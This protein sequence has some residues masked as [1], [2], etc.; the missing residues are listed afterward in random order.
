MLN[1]LL[2]ALFP[3]IFFLLG[4]EEALIPK[5]STL[6]A[7]DVAQINIGDG[8]SFIACGC[9]EVGENNGTVLFFEDP[10]ICHLD[11]AVSKLFFIYL[12]T[13]KTM[14][15]IT[16]DNSLFNSSPLHNPESSNPIYFYYIPIPPTTTSI[17]YKDLYHPGIR[18][19][20]IIP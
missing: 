9:M 17:F 13:N 3:L 4:C 12:P 11:L 10:L 16:S 20:I 7:K 15:Q 8:Y 19:E 5:T 1:S 6:C 14:H 18:G 2:K